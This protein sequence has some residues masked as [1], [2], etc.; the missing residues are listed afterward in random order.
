M[1]RPI[2]TLPYFWCVSGC[3][4]SDE[5]I[6]ISILRRHWW[7]LPTTVDIVIICSL[8]FVAIVWLKLIREYKAV[9]SME[10][11]I[12]PDSRTRE[13]FARLDWSMQS[14][15]LVFCLIFGVYFISIGILLRH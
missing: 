1:D 5:I 12:S 15:A 14:S 3:C 7:S 10:A 9:R 8:I 11:A 4:V 2:W 13:V 6:G